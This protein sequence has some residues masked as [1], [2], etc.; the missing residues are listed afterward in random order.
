LAFITVLYLALEEQVASLLKESA[1]LFSRPAS[2]TVRHS[3]SL[4]LNIIFESKVSAA[5]SAVHSA[6]SD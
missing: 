6:G 3:D 4:A 5:Y 1:L 2:T